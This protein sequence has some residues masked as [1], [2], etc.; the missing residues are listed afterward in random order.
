MYVFGP[1]ALVQ[2]AVTVLTDVGHVVRII[3]C[4]TSQNDLKE[5]IYNIMD[6]IRMYKGNSGTRSEIILQV[7]S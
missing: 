5:P 1:Y 2:A 3:N 6:V 4:P 7:V